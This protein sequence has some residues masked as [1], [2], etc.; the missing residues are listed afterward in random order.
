MVIIYDKDA[1]LE[2]HV[3]DFSDGG[4]KLVVERV[5]A[6][7]SKVYF[8]DLNDKTI[9]IPII[10]K[11]TSGGVLQ[12]SMEIDRVECY[13]VTWSDDYTFWYDGEEIFKLQSEKRHNEKMVDVNNH[14][15]W[16][17]IEDVM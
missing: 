6:N 11:C 16:L 3:H 15:K 2:R 4:F 10:A 14:Y 13:L 7:N 12:I 9:S 1:L 8:T 5:N 17:R